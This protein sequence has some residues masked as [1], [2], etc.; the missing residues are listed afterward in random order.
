M[1]HQD[2]TSF[3]AS[4]FMAVVKRELAINGRRLALS[5]LALFIG[6]AFFMTFGN[7]IDAQSST[8][9]EAVGSFFVLIVFSLVTTIVAAT[10]F[11]ELKSKQGRISLLMLPATGAEKILAQVLIYYV[12]TIVVFFICAQAADLV[13]IVVTPWL[14]PDV[15]VQGPINFLKIAPNIMEHD[16][17]LSKVTTD[18]YLPVITTLSLLAAPFGYM[19]GAIIAPRHTWIKVMV[20]SQIV[21]FVIS[22]IALLLFPLFGTDFYEFIFRIIINHTSPLIFIAFTL[23]YVIIIALIF[24]MFRRKDVI[25]RTMLG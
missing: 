23:E 14:N 7:A 3:N 19:L 10:A 11:G 22:T 1:N 15:F 17:G 24:I 6:L 2:N 18:S 25:S 8:H 21:S 13:R 20:A 12:G 9:P 16:P 4:R 5:A